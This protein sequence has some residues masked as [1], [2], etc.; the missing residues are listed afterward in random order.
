LELVGKASLPSAISSLGINGRV[1]V[2]GV[3]S[4]AR[5]EL[6][7]LA[8]MGRRARIHGSTLRSRTISEKAEVAARVERHVLP[9]L[10]NGKIRVPLAST[11]LLHQA[12][13]A[14]DTFAAGGKLGKMVLLQGS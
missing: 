12:N 10:V 5:M 14:Y 2:I 8:L 4:G 3:G 9:L 11:P 1:A 6:D 13:E 7:L